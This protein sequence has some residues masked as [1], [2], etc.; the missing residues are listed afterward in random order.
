MVGYYIKN[1]P[2][3]QIFQVG[4]EESATL[5]VVGGEERP[6]LDDDDDDVEARPV[7]VEA[8]LS[9]SWRFTAK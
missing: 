7:G 1:I 3:V 5:G 6:R 2:G 8:G 9:D 4:S